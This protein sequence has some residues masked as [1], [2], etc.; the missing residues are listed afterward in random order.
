MTDR[1]E[2]RKFGANLMLGMDSLFWGA[3]FFIFVFRRAS[4][5]S[6]KAAWEFAPEVHVPLVGALIALCLLPYFYR[7]KLWAIALLFGPAA[8]LA[9]GSCLRFSDRMVLDAGSRAPVI[10]FGFFCAAFSA[11]IL[12]LSV[13]GLAVRGNPI[14][15]RLLVSQAFFA[16]LI[17]PVVFTW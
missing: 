11:H 2:L 6:W 4:A 14:F 1:S 5:D 13:A 7:G 12:V 8:A 3:A 9:L 10:A 15:R 17:L 16:L